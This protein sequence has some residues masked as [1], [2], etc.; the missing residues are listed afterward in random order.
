MFKTGAR[1]APPPPGLAPPILWGDDATVRDRLSPWFTEI[2]TELVPV[3]FDLPTHPAG[4]VA[5][6]RQYFGP[7]KVAFSRLDEPAQAAMAADLEALWASA[8]TSPNP[9]SHTLIKNQYLQV[10]AVRK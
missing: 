9:T 1:H 4:A 2:R 10:T 3:D 7:T 6:F 5:F 8:N